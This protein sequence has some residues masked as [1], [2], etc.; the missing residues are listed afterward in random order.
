EQ[1]LHVVFGRGLQET[2]TGYGNAVDMQVGDT[3]PGQCRRVDFQYVA[4]LEKISH[5]PV[6]AGARL[7]GREACSRAPVCHGEGSVL[8]AADVF[9][10]A[11]I[12]LDDFT[13]LHEQRH[14]YHG[15]G[16]QGG[17]RAAGAGGGALDARIGPD[18][19]QLNEVRRCGGQLYAVPQRHG[20]HVLFLHPDAAV[21]DGG[22]VSGLLLEAGRVHEVVELTVV[23]QVLQFHVDDVSAFEGFARLESPFPDLAGLQVAQAHPVESLALAR[24]DEFVLDDG[25]GIALEHYFQTGFEIIGRIGCHFSPAGCR[26]CPHKGPQ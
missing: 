9:A 6:Q 18:D 12:H 8:D 4:C 14:A 21:A 1:A 26:S 19:F 24:L 17:W 20:A 7:Q 13:L 22:R 2:V 10:A 11:G 3:V 5:L 16:G 15:A 23:V 25:T